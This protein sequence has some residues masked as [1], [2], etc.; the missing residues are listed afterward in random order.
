[1]LCGPMLWYFHAR[2]GVTTET[3]ELVQRMVRSKIARA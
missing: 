2:E 3:V 1:M